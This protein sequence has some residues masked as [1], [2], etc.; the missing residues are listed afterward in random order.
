M[1]YMNVDTDISIDVIDLLESCD[2]SEI[3]EII[4][5]LKAERHIARNAYPIT[6]SDNNPDDLE[7]DRLLSEAIGNRFKLTSEDK[8]LIKEA[9]QKYQF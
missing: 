5:W 3:L 9:L 1:P 7:F 2:I 6:I 8:L 4:D